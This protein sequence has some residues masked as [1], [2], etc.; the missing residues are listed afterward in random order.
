METI[1]FKIKGVAA[2]LFHNARLADP[3]NYYA[4]ELKKYSGKRGKT[5]SDRKAMSEIEWKGGIYLNDDNR[6]VIPGK[7]IEAMLCK[8]AT[9]ANKGILFKSSVF[10]PE[11]S[12]LEYDGD[13]DPEKLCADPKYSL[14][15]SVRIKK[16]RI[17][18]T[19]PI[20]RAWSATVAVSFYP[21]VVNKDD[22][23]AAMEH[24]GRLVGLCDW[25]PRYG[26]FEI[27]K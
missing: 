22:V 21:Q 20:F 14:I 15:E 19:R 25:R 16:D 18:R 1:Q 5:E 7:C 3:D 4:V 17:M 12:I 2:I 27:E 8:A 9:K 24:G 10:V 13:E 26:R 11:D 23:V 6:V